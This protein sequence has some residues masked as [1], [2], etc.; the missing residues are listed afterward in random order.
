VRDWLGLFVGLFVV[1]M[2]VGWGRS[3]V[4]VVWAVG[5][6][7]VLLVLC[8]WLC[9]VLLFVLVGMGVS[10]GWLAAIDRLLLFLDGRLLMLTV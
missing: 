5:L 9:V 2:G 10:V 7:V 4:I 3:C 8:C 6:E 1:Q